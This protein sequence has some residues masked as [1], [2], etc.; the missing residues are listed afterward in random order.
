VAY[1]YSRDNEAEA[2]E[3]SGV[4]LYVSTWFFVAAAEALCELM[5]HD[6]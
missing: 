4:M 6:N 2:G 1:V 5:A 3:R